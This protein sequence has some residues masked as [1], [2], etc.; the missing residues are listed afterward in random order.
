MN[1]K[2]LTIIFLIIL[3]ITFIFLSPHKHELLIEEVSSP[4]EFLLSTNEKFC[5]NDL[6]FF[7]SRYSDKNKKYAS[8]INISEDEA[9]IIGNLTNYWAKNILSGRKVVIQS[10]DIIYNKQSYKDKF[11]NSAF[12]IKEGIVVNKE[13]FEKLLKTIDTKKYVIVDIDS[14]IEYPVSRLNAQNIKNFV[15]IRQSH[16][17]KIF[18]QKKKEPDIKTEFKPENILDLGFLKIIL[19]DHTNKLKP[20]RNCSND[21]CK[22]LV[23]QIE[24]AKDT[25]DIA[26]YGYSTVP[27]IETA[28]KN[29]L[30]RGVKIRLIYDLD[31][32]SKNIYE[33]T[34]K[35]ASIIP[36]N[37]S[38]IQ[39]KENTNIMHN[40]FY[41][42]DKKT[43]VTGS[44]NL[45]NTDMSGFNSNVIAVIKSPQIAQIYQH[46]FEQ[47]YA[48]N[49]H[50]SKEK[51]NK[52]SNELIQIF[53]SPQDNPIDTAVIPII[54]N[55]K[56][57][58]YIPTFF[59]TDTKLVNELIL[60]HKRGVDVKIIADSLN[61]SNRSSKQKIIRDS[62]ILLKTENYAGKMHAKSIIADDKYLIIGSMNFS[63]TANTK[64]D[65]NLIVINNTAA[66]KFY[67][68]FF[69]YQWDRIPDK[70]LK[71]TAGAESY[72]SIGSCFDGIDNDYDGFTDA[73]D[74]A[75]NKKFKK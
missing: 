65:E 56:K 41:I 4:K 49:F 17:K 32:K 31:K 63:N 59:I 19:S 16:F 42:F 33:N 15:V 40:K 29:A 50:N 23:Y 13:Q 72:D 51:I 22:E 68:T 7:D 39:S 8:R 60:A 53:F 9:F 6:D 57:Y 71:L 69:L 73:D 14:D 67:K 61:A 25:I 12:F 24:S 34:D 52:N 18:K 46:E 2:I 27:K 55:A 10:G 5:I 47:M 64:N 28:I 66:A 36:D 11:K 54:R 35:L 1:K 45:S 58:I 3:F 37:K 75:C 48:G 20:D 38:D 26:I 70:W 30:K 62:G 21:I 43:V 44:A 74:P